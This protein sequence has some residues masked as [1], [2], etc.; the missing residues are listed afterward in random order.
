MRN[1]KNLL[2]AMPLA[3]L[4]TKSLQHCQDQMILAIIFF[5]KFIAILY[6]LKVQF[7]NHTTF[8][9]VIIFRQHLNFERI[10]ILKEPRQW[11]K[12]TNSLKSLFCTS[13]REGSPKI[14]DCWCAMLYHSSGCCQISVFLKKKSWNVKKLYKKFLWKPYCCRNPIIHVKHL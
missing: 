8:L 13:G 12:K 3:M 2:E 11:Q 5:Y 10:S 1:T 9:L 4:P 6:K 14:S 7:C